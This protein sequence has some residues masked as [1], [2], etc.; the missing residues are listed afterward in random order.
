MSHQNNIYQQ[1]YLKYKVKYLK[2]QDILNNVTGGGLATAKNSFFNKIFNN[3]ELMYNLFKADNYLMKKLSE[4]QLPIFTELKL[5]ELKQNLVLNEL[6]SLIVANID[7]KLMDEYLKIYLNGNL[8]SSNSI[9]NKGRYKDQQLKLKKLKDNK[10]YLK[11][12]IPATFDSLA[13]LEQFIKTNEDNLLKIDK[14]NQSKRKTNEV[15]K[16]IKEEGE[17]DVNII[18]DTPNLIVYNPTTESGAKFYGR[19][20]RWCTA[21]NN[22]NMFCYY[23]N[24]GPLYI[25]QSK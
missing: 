18:L 16:I 1:K 13:D 5:D 11:L 22:S 6:F 8:G 9:E 3:K 20:T 25:I 19:G 24:E 2:L 23:N 7:D 12:E 15:H 17:S 14:K 21:A 10:Q 4:K